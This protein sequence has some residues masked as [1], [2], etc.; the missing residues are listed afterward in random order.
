MTVLPNKPL[1][2]AVVH[3]WLTSPGGAERVL[4]E[5][6]SS[7]PQADL[8]T[9]VDFLKPQHR[10]LLKGREPK[11][12]F[13]QRMPFARTKH[14]LYLPLM[15]IAIEQLDMTGYDLVIS[16]SYAVAKGVLTGPEQVHLSYV[17][18]P[19]RYAW[20]LQ[21]QYLEEM[22]L[23]KGPLSVC[24]RAVL[25]YVRLWDLRSAV[26]VD[27]VLANSKYVG[28]QISRIYR[29]EFS[30][31][32]PPVELD[33]F[34]L[35]LV[36]ENYY[37]TASRMV[38]YKRIDLIVRSFAKMPARRLVVIGD[39]PEMKRVLDAAEGHSNIEIMGYRSDEE[40]QRLVSK[41]RAFV[42]AAIEDFGISPVEAQASGTP[43]IC[44]GRAGTLETVQPLESEEPTGVFFYDQT[45]ES[46][47]GAVE[48][49][50]RS[51]DRIKPINCRR[52]AERFG[53]EKFRTGL[54]RFVD[55][56][57]AEQRDPRTR[58]PIQVLHAFPSL[59]VKP[60]AER[61]TG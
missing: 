44:L 47:M 19:I 8:F 7:Y 38:P 10:H 14:W 39:G 36:K 48:E 24:V 26:N 45:E 9:V 61:A 40:L 28:L 52:N 50:E 11:T 56:A 60:D 32:P 58:A 59:V 4:A 21:H 2:V 3:D 25:H 17:H 27:K 18:T 12:T 20:H 31:L 43:V 15:P 5:I 34:R 1:R 35:E 30:V 29:Q 33:R 53:S 51:G 49:F 37:V 13:I 42:F 55:E 46:I 41:A 23:T 16:S 57:L 22:H 6:L 54:R